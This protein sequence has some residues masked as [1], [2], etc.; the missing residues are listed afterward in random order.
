MVLL[1]LGFDVILWKVK[2]TGNLRLLKS[3]RFHGRT[4][5][6]V[7]CSQ[8]KVIRTNQYKAVRQQQRVTNTSSAGP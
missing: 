8:G 2:K 1:R 7:Q 3:A 6:H 5:L 4:R